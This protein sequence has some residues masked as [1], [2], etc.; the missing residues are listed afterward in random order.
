MTQELALTPQQQGW[1]SLADYKQQVFKSL[2][3]GELAV[4]ATLANLPTATRE[5]PAQ[6]STALATVQERLKTAKAQ[7]MQNKDIRLAFTGML[8]EKLI[9]P[10]MDFEKRSE[11]LIAT[12]SQHELCLRKIAEAIE[13]EAAE[14][15]KEE[16]QLQ[17]H[18]VNENYR[19]QT[20]YKNALNRWITDYYASQL[21][22]K[23]P[24][25]DLEDLAGILSEVKVPLPTTFQLRMVTKERAMEI[26]SSIQKP[27]LKAVLQSAIASLNER[28]SMY[29]NDLQNAEAAAKAAEEAQQK[30][31]A[32]AKQSVELTTATNTLMAQA[33]TTVVNAPHVKRNLK[34]VEE[35]TQQWGVAVM[36]HFLRNLQ[37]AA[38]K[39]RVKSWAKLN[40]GQMAEALAKIAGETGEVF[41]G[42]KMEEVEK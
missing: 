41:T 40:I 2:Q 3:Q 28:F 6:L 17:A 10:A 15:R 5:N 35:N 12:A 23:T 27:D 9:D 19:I 16:Q 1:L 38:P 29:A 32:D 8:K 22:K 30:A 39:V 13:Q 25:P 20:E 4:Q 21:R 7:H 36:G 37:T 14:K 26:Y 24:T 42:L 33:E 31:E 11:V 18:I 34:I